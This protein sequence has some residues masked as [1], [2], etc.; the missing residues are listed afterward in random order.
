LFVE[1]LARLCSG[2]DVERGLRTQD[3]IE[4][5]DDGGR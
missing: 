1:C 2:P 4:L 3:A 5:Y